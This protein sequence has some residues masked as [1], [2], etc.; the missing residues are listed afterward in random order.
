MPKNIS[1][2]TKKVGEPNAPRLTAS[3][4]KSISLF[5]TSSCCARAISR[6]ISMPDEMKRA[7]EHLEVVHLLRLFPHVMVGGAEIRL[8]HA[9]ELGRDGA[10]HQHQRIDR[11]ERI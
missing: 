6:S 8:E 11:E 4:V 5:L 3:V 7:A 2:P 10:P 1:V 9:L